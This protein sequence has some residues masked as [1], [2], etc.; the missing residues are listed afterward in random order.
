[1]RKFFEDDIHEE[2]SPVGFQ[3]LFALTGM[4][5]DEG[6]MFIGGLPSNESIGTKPTA[7]LKKQLKRHNDEQNSWKKEL[8]YL[9][10]NLKPKEV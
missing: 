2:I 8:D 10:K 9:C 5:T 4:S 3:N 6:N 1:M 7:I